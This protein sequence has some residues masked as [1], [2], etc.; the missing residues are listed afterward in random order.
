[1]VDKSS[2]SQKVPLSNSQKLYRA[3]T[4]GF[5]FGTFSYFGVLV[6]SIIPGVGNLFLV[7]LYLTLFSCR[8]L[9]IPFSSDFGQYWNFS[10]WFFVALFS[11]L[12]SVLF[13]FVIIKI[14]ES[15]KKKL[16]K[17]KMSS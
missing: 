17:E 3:G 6:Y 15:D 8:L 11:I 12:Y 16:N 13:T 10:D 5:W 4:I 7:P 1:M 9:R 2:K 14:K